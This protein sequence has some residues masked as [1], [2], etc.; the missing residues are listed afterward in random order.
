MTSHEE[1]DAMKMADLKAKCKELGVSGTGALG[2]GGAAWWKQD[3]GD[4]A[5]FERDAIGAR[6]PTSGAG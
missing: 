3:S 1:I 2:V 6:P 5:F 4:L